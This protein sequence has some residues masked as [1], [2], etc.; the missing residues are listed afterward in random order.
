MPPW[1]RVG[2]PRVARNEA[3]V[4]CRRARLRGRRP[5]VHE[6][7]GISQVVGDDPEA[8]PSGHAVGAM[9]A[10]PPESMPTFDHA[11]AAFAADAPP[12]AAPKP[13]LPFIRTPRVRLRA[14]AW[15]HHASYPSVRGRVFIPRG[16]EA[17]I[18]GRQVGARPKMA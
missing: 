1:Q 8:H 3:D 12:L 7:R 6:R 16:A 5:R 4:A 15:Q 11:D 18:P 17:P 2:G 10:T 9:I 13:R 14:A